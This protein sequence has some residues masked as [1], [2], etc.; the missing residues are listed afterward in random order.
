MI[1]VVVLVVVAAID[2]V[3]AFSAPLNWQK[4]HSE[5]HNLDIKCAYSIKV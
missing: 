3:D 1:V 4:R 5:L 2:D